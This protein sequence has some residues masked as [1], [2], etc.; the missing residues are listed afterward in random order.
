MKLSFIDSLVLNSTR[1]PGESQAQSVSRRIRQARDQE[2]D[3]LWRE[4]TEG[5]D[6][7]STA[8]A[9]TAKEAEAALAARVEDLA[10]AGQARR[11]ARAVSMTKPP[12]ADPDRKKELEALFPKAI[13]GGEW[14]SPQPGRPWRDPGELW[15]G[16]A[17]AARRTLMAAHVAKSIRRPARRTAPGPLGSRPEHWEVLTATQDG[18]ERFAALIVKLALGEVPRGVVRGHS[19]GEIIA[20]QKDNGGMR[21]L[22]HAQHPAPNGPGCRHESD[23]GPG[24]GRRRQPPAGDRDTR[25]LC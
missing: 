1:S 15:T 23:P 14:G 12:I 9:R 6:R 2:W 25:W 24:Q 7:A 13:Q 8:A 21:P 22:D 3:S 18:V 17:G 19:R 16:Q 10:N 20:I 4:V 11:A 5:R